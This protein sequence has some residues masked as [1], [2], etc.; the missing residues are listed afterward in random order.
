[1]CWR[2]AFANVAED[3]DGATDEKMSHF[4]AQALH[5]LPRLA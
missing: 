2:H 1:M 4:C 3:R 5:G